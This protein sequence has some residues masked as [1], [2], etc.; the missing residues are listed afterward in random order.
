MNNKN[1]NKLIVVVTLIIAIL[2]LGVSL[3]AIS[4]T[5]KISGYA[6]SVNNGKWDIHFENLSKVQ[7]TGKAQEVSR[8]IINKN[9]TSIDRFK[10]EFSSKTD[11]V[12]YEF[13]VVNDGNLDAKVS[14]I[15][16]LDPICKGVSEDI[17]TAVTDAETVCNSFK[18][19]LYYAN[20]SR[21]MIDD[22]LPA[23]SKKT[24]KLIMRYIGNTWPTERV[25]LTNLSASIIYSQS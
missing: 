15:S 1:L 4:S 3:V 16:I 12:A 25:E 20:G 18:Y 14:T 6:S 11:V 8:P 19:E 13:N 5:V 9:S 7:I 23:G 10:V 17:T 2:G 24:L 21:I 22:L